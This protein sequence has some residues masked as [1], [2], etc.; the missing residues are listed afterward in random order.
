[1]SNF[2]FD[3]FHQGLGDV[4]NLRSA[5]HA[6][7]AS[8]LANADT[9]NYHARYIPFDQ[10]LGEVVDRSASPEMKRTDS[11]HKSGLH[12]DA[13]DPSIEELEPPAWSADGNSVQLEKE[14]VRLT[15]NSMMY[16]AV[17]KGLSKRLAL[18]KFAASD[19]RG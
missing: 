8:N 16:G 7:T 5:Q 2:L 17:S 13:R 15:E 6:L 3:A 1:M 4:L 10:I 14:T 19:G 12:G 18:L 9:P 11:R